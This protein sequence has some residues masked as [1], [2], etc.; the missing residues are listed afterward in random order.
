MAMFSLFIFKGSCSIKLSY[1]CIIHEEEVNKNKEIAKN[2][3]G[4]TISQILL[5]DVMKGI[6]ETYTVYNVYTKGGLI[7]E[8]FSLSLKLFKK[9]D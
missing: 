6:W 9:D 1:L 3:H 8:G 7:S 5:T 2:R 4:S